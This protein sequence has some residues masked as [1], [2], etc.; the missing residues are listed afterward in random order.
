MQP[1]VSIPVLFQ[2][3][4][5]ATGAKDDAA[6]SSSGGPDVLDT[7]NPVC[8][9]DALAF[10]IVSAREGFDALE[11]DW[12]ALFDRAGRPA[13]AFQSFNWLWHWANHYLAP[14][15]APGLAIVTVR[16]AGRLI[17]VWP[18]VRERTAGLD[19]LAWMGAPV[20]QY[21]DILVDDL[22][23]ADAVIR[24]SWMYI[25]TR[26][27]PDLVRLR[28]VR[29]DAAVA[30]LLAEIGASSSE[31]QQAPFLDLASAPDFDAY[32]TRYPA[33]ARKNRRR[34][35]RRLE[36]CGSVAFETHARGEAAREL[37]RFGLSLKR[38]WLSGKGLVS[39]ALADDR[40][41]RFI[42]DTAD[43]DDRPTGCRVSVLRAAGEAAAIQIAYACKGRL[44][45]HV[46]VYAAPFEKAGAG[47]LLIEESLRR[48]KA[49]GIETFDLLAPGDAYKMDWAD[50]A[51][52]VEDFAVELSRAG[53]LYATIYLGFV[54]QR[55]KAAITALP[56]SVRRRV[57]SSYG[58]LLALI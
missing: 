15:A 47:N 57:A 55:L 29:A 53:K 8:R 17:L 35:M 23:D 25:A 49:D 5:P 32:E 37:A 20:S 13:Q 58:L 48:A 16:R 27:A 33:K 51:V 19:C 52:A 26:L 50:G 3:V 38:A 18:L 45:V 12:N 1:A 22:P 56:A 11:Q 10:E 2:G 40:M 34:Q 21:G 24:A 9:D 7:A 28:K 30:P 46:I 6:R 4:R 31:R 42:A 39:P 14:S 36:E 54:R 41:T 43:C 44:L